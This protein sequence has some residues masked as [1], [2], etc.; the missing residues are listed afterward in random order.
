M[1]N[2]GNAIGIF[3]DVCFKSHNVCVSVIYISQCLQ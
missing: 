1:W 2:V 3:G